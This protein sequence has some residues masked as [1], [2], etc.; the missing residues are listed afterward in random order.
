MSCLD[1]DRFQ[2]GDCL[3][4]QGANGKDRIPGWVEGVAPWM[5]YLTCNQ[6][7]D[8]ITHSVISLVI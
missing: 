7:A 2:L 3:D 4:G 1:L 5:I 6:T 8:K